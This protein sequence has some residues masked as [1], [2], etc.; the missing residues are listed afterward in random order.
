MTDSFLPRPSP[1]PHDVFDECDSDTPL[2]GQRVMLNDENQ[3][4]HGVSYIS[5]QG[6]RKKEEDAGVLIS[7]HHLSYLRAANARPKSPSPV[8]RFILLTN[9]PPFMLFFVW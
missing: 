5:E 9:P 4:G 2:R 1:N 8:S 6:A 3:E 7:N